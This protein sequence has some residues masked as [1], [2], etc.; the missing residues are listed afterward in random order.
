[1][2]LPGFTA[3]NSTYPTRSF[4]IGPSKSRQGNKR[5][6]GIHA[7]AEQPEHTWR[8]LHW[9]YFGNC[10]HRH[11]RLTGTLLHLSKRRISLLHRL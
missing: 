9:P 4:K 7:E 2:R 8:Q 6:P 3:E 11:V 10:H 1:M 5:Q